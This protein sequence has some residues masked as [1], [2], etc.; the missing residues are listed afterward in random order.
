MNPSPPAPG[1]P[2]PPPALQ[3]GWILAVDD[4]APIRQLLELVLKTHGYRV[5]T[6][7]GAESALAALQQA[8]TPPLLVIC[9]VLMPDVDGLELVRRMSARR[10]G[11]NVIFISGHLTDVSWWPADLKD[12]RFMTKPFGNA[13]LIAEVRNALRAGAG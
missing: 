8:E 1:S 6:A 12:H 9:D 3:P 13:E 11:L 4:E 5:V 10:R 2:R 7:D